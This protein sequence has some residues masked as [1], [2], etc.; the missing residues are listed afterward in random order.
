[1]ASEHVALM[2]SLTLPEIGVGTDTIRAQLQP[3]PE[4]DGPPDG[5]AIGPGAAE[6]PGAAEAP[7]PAE[8][9]PAMPAATPGVRRAP[10][11]GDHEQ[12]QGGAAQ[13]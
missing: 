3:V 9:V 12:D 2:E 1:M 13:C 6:V 4:M 11:G 8:A 10:G 5:P 7:R